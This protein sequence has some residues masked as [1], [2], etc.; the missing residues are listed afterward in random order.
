VPI[1]RELV[2]DVAAW[3]GGWLGHRQRTLRIPGLQFAIAHQGQIVM[4]GAHGMADL[5]AGEALT[6]RH[7]FHIASHSKTFTATA[8]LQLAETDP[9]ALRLD[10]PLVRH[11]PASR[12]GL[13]Q[14]AGLTITDLLHHGSGMTRDGAD[15]DYWQLQRPFPDGDELLDLL[16]RSPSPFPANDR[17]H[18]SNIAYS[19]LGRVIEQVA[20]CSYGEYVQRSIIDR[21][22]LA[23][24]APD[25]DPRGSDRSFATGYTS[26]DDGLE[27]V[28]IDHVAANAMAP[29]TGFT[30]T[31]RDLCLY[32]SAHCLG[33]Q[34]L[35]SDDSK[36]R[37]QHGWWAPRAQEQYGL[38]L[39][40][41]DLGE[42]RLI[43]HSGGYPGHITRT[44]CDPKEQLVVSVLCNASDAAAT[45]LCSGIFSLLEH[46]SHPDERIPEHADGVDLR[47]FTG[48]F[49]TLS[50]AFD[51][52]RFGSRLLAIPTDD[53]DPTEV[54]G[55]LVAED[56]DTTMLVLAHDG[57]TSEGERFQFTRDGSGR[58]LSVRAFSG[59]TAYPDDEY[60]RRF[61]SGGGVRAP[62]QEGVEGWTG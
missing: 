59:M 47:S 27:R 41:I 4:T 31:A 2:D 33:D 53:N 45:P 13:S 42:R 17:F 52:A 61:L 22:G 58:V 20:G 32:F 62:H 49:S 39:Q 46:L 28:P 18:Y 50:G 60:V 36:R 7:A 37:M 14:L 43:G 25:F 35:L 15:G 5:D 55:E 19:V 51:V 30:S 10:D 1:T 24:T 29:A 11:L 16:E 40:L 48:H 9:P 26:A 12:A 6:T 3:A 8:I 34:R 54:L 23:D 56:P 38:G 21:L 44:W 57:Y